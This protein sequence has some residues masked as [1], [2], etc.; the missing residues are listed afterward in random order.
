VGIPESQVTLLYP[1]PLD[2][3][4]ISNGNLTQNP[5]HE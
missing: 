2:E 4:T 5:E 1:I 3:I